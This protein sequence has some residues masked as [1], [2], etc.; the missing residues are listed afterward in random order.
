[1][2][3]LV[4]RNYYYSSKI[5]IKWKPAETKSLLSLMELS[6]LQK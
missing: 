3:Q 2:E 4:Q 5:L 6:K 1:M